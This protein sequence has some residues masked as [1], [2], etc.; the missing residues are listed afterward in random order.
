MACF[1]GILIAKVQRVIHTW[2]RHQA[3]DV[4]TQ[5]ECNV[6]HGSSGQWHQR[7]IY[8]KCENQ[9]VHEGKSINSSFIPEIFYIFIPHLTTWDSLP[10]YSEFQ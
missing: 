8:D 3:Q 7:Q 4:K 9:D 5:E 10:D 1:A 6:F 2:R